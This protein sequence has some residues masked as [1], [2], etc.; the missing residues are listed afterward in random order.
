MVLSEYKRTY[1]AFHL[2]VYIERLFSDCYKKTFS[3]NLE[4]W[5]R[6][7]SFLQS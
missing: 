5:P 3:F 7:N 6:S 1:A 2:A 4:K